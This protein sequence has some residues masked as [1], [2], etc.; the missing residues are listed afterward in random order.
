MFG[1][2]PDTAENGRL[3]VGFS[4]GPVKPLQDG[5]WYGDGEDVKQSP[6]QVSI[7]ARVRAAVFFLLSL[8]RKNRGWQQLHDQGPYTAYQ[9]FGPNRVEEEDTT[10]SQRLHGA[11]E[12][13]RKALKSIHMPLYAG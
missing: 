6:S 2:L 8:R 3:R 7:F 11:K 13:T 5:E 10:V 4:A 9:P 12:S 1:V